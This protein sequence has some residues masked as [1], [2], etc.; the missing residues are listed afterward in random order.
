MLNGGSDQ[1]KI[2]DM[3][4]YRTKKE[5][6]SESHKLPAELSKGKKLFETWE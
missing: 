5:Y 3:R 2:L 6:G 4:L 1:V